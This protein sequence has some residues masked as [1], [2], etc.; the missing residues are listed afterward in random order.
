MDRT[1]LPPA[2]EL[3]GIRQ[4][5][6]G[7]INKYELSFRLPDGSDYAYEA[8]SRKGLEDFHRS[9][10]AR[11]AGKPTPPDAV[12]IVPR[13]EGGELLLIRE[14]R[15]PLNSWCIAFPAGLVEEGEDLARAVDRELREET[16][17][18]LATGGGEPALTSLPQP[19][20]SS[21][22]LTDEA[23]QVVFARVAKA[24]GARPERGEL[25]EPFLLPV[26]DI[27]AFL[28]SNA[29]PMGTRAQL[30]L[31]LFCR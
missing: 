23:V 30:I 29:L 26:A 11:G 7:W 10:E 28:E 6:S 9:M 2:P 5:A 21:T 16:G 20:F 14:F 15:Y 12:C 18:A 13:T 4:V 3:V 25:I 31:Q 27:P 19:G 1:I 17:Y 24:E 8:T 22:G